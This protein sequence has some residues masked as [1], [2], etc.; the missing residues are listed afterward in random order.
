VDAAR[1]VVWC[2]FG[3]S[4]PVNVSVTL[5]NS[6]IRPATPGDCE[7]FAVTDNWAWL[8][9]DSPVCRVSDGDSGYRDDLVNTGR[10]AVLPGVPEFGLSLL[11][12]NVSRAVRQIAAS[13]ESTP[14]RQIR[15]EEM[16]GCAPPAAHPGIETIPAGVFQDFR[17][18]SYRKF[19]A[20]RKP[21]LKY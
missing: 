20:G 10:I 2:Q 15:D 1:R 8:L 18:L 13:Y 12:P 3:R 4:T 16:P 6:K 14:G 5:S 7:M 21:G 11:C 19:E 9:P 17:K